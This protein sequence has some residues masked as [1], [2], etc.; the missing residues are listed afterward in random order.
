MS[1]LWSKRPFLKP[2]I[3][4]SLAAE[5]NEVVAMDIK[6]FRNYILHLIDHVTRFS[7]AAIVKCKENKTYGN[8]RTAVRTTLVTTMIIMK[9]I[10]PLNKLMI[11]I[12]RILNLE[13][14]DD[15]QAVDQATQNPKSNLQNP[16]FQHSKTPKS[17]VTIQY[18]LPDE[19]EIKEAK[20]L[21]HAGRATGNNKYW[22]NIQK[23]DDCVC[24]INLEQ[25][26][27]WEEIKNNETVSVR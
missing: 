19:N 3:A 26:K 4:T 21:G 12:Y 9:K 7:A 24:S 15:Q 17:G 20:E 18:Q 6:V 27:Q 13:H 1:N 22:V 11:K 8:S 10:F 14:A 5:F 25:L 16:T 23:P 2:V